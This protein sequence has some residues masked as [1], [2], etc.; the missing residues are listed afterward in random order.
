MAL[1]LT[2]QSALVTGSSRGIGRGIAIKLAECGVK[3]IAVHYL[4][5]K[6]EAER[7]AHLIEQRGARAVLIQADVTKPEDIGRMFAEARRAVGPLGVFVSNARP[8]VQHFYQPALDLTLEQSRS[9]IDSQATA[10]LLAARDAAGMMADQGGRIVAITYA[11]GSRTGS[12][13]SW[14]A[15]GPA[16][17]AMESLLRYLA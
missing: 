13:R 16:K 4:K 1:Q 7:T 17:A 11:P 9:A 8:D 5:R 6:D 2:I 15:M 14:A 3:R 10:L 12:W